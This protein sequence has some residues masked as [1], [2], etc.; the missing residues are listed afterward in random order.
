MRMLVPLT[1]QGA[2]RVILP[3]SH[4]RVRSVSVTLANASVAYHDCFTDGA[5]SCSG[6]SDTPHPT[7]RVRLTAFKR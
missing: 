4:R 2:G 3:F 6:R 7:F 5:Y 1:A